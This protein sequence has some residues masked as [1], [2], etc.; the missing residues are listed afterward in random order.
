MSQPLAAIPPAVPMGTPDGG[1]TDAD[2]T[3]EQLIALFSGGAG[4]EAGTFMYRCPHRLRS[5]SVRSMSRGE[6]AARAAAPR[7]T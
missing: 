6:S 3:D 2:A 4:L 7:M 5:R 1:S